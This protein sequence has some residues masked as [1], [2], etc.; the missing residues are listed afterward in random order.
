MYF[1]VRLK[2]EISLSYTIL[3]ILAN[4]EYTLANNLKPN[5]YVEFYEPV[6]EIQET[7]SMVNM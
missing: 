5:L 3:N 6:R 1:S 2:N 7:L 4:H